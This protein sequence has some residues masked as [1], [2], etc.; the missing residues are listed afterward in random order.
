MRSP[1]M[2]YEEII[3][4]VGQKYNFNPSRYVGMGVTFSKPEDHFVKYQ[5]IMSDP[6]PNDGWNP[7]Y[8]GKGETNDE[9]RTIVRDG[10]RIKATQE[11]YDADFKLIHEQFQ[12]YQD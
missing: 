10:K 5:R 9:R 4:F 7:N 3:H 1:V 12:R 6:Q 11:E 2:D 8:S